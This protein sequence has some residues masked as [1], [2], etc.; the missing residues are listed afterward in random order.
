LQRKQFAGGHP[1]SLWPR[2]HLAITR[3]PTRIKD[4][5]ILKS[6]IKLPYAVYENQDDG[7]WESQLS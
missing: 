4:D 7:L 5:M 2:S 3:N 6:L 1:Q